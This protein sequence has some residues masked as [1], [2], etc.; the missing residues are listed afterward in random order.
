MPQ[1]SKTGSSL[2]DC[3][4]SYPDNSFGSK[5]YLS[6]VIP[7]VY[8]TAPAD[9]APDGLMSYPGHS[10]VGEFY[11]SVEIPS[12]Y[13]TVPGHSLVGGGHLT[14][15]QRFRRCILQF[16]QTGPP[17]HSLLVVVVGGVLPLCRDSVGV[18][19]RRNLCRRVRCPPPTNECPGTVEYTAP[20]D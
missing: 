7:S 13:S 9:W 11:L 5:S 19:Y 1:S 15:L 3:L 12:V 20:T 18:F 14:R 8:S 16:Q 10:L 6:T 17:G 2:S 4:M